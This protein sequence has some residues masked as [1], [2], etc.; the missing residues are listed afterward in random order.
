MILNGKDLL[1][2]KQNNINELQGHILAIKKRKKILIMAHQILGYPDFETNYRMLKLFNKYGIDLVEL[3]IPFSEP[4]ADGPLFLKANQ[5]SLKNGTS[6]EECLSFI[7]KIKEEFNFS[8]I[9][10]TYYNILYHYGLEK[11]IS[12][13]KAIGVSGFIIPDA[14]PEESEDYI[15]LCKKY[16]LASILLVT[17]YT[18]LE[19]LSSLAK[20]STGMLYCVARKGVTGSKTALDDSTIDF[21]NRCRQSTDLPLGIG[22]G[23]SSIEDIQFLSGKKIDIAIM[24]SVFLRTL[25]KDGIEEVEKFLCKIKLI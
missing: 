21:I 5:E 3:Q 22:F 20:K 15:D 6:V 12:K 24:G 23:I 11:F 8:L 4:I 10:M 25:E 1:Q 14:L 16:R 13:A 17:P 7:K 9:C 2:E 19:R 18:S